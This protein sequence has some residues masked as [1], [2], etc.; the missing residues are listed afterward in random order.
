MRLSANPNRAARFGSTPP[1]Q[2][3]C[4]GIARG[5]NRSW[6]VFKWPPGVAPRPERRELRQSAPV[7]RDSFSL[8]QRI[9][10]RLKPSRDSVPVT[11][12]SSRFPDTSGVV[13]TV[14]GVPHSHKLCANCTYVTRRFVLALAS[15]LGPP[16][17]PFN[18]SGWRG[19]KSIRLV[20]KA[21]VRKPTLSIVSERFGRARTYNMARASSKGAATQSSPICC[22]R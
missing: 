11:G 20:K 16:P 6:A 4:R 19:G 21:D 3:I 17:V 2:A 1:C 13:P 7:S 22:R 5:R 12:L 18:G 15:W 10:L 9:P 8:V 14:R